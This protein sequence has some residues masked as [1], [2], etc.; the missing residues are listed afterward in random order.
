MNITNYNQLIW[1]LLLVP[2]LFFIRKSLVNRRVTFRNLAAVLRI[3]ALICLILALT[4]PFYTSSTTDI[5]AIFLID[6]SSSVD[7]NALTDSVTKITTAINSLNNNDSYGIYLFANGVKPVTLENLPTTI[8]KLGT[9]I[10]SSHFRSKSA[11]AEAVNDIK[12]L[13]PANKSKLLCLFSDGIETEGGLASAL[14]DLREN[15]IKLTLKKLSSFEKPEVS[16]VELKANTKRAYK[17]EVIRVTAKLLSNYTTKAKLRFLVRGVVVHEVP[18]NL[19]KNKETSLTYEFDLQAENSGIWTAEVVPVKDYFPANNYASCSVDMLGKVK[20]LVL[21][22][23]PTKLRAFKKAI[24]KQEVSV[25]IRTKVGVPSSFSELCEYDAVMLADIE[26]DSFTTRQ[27]EFM[28]KY[29][30]DFGG[31]LIMTGSENS[32]GLGG[33]Y[34]TPIEKVLPLNSRYEKEKEHPSLALVLIIDKSGSMSGAP[35]VLAREAAR[36]VLEVL[37]IRDQIGIIAFDGSAKVVA[38]LTSAVNKSS[39][40]NAIETIGAGGGTN[41]YPAME[42]GRDLLASASAKIKHM[43][44]LSDGQSSGGDF[45]GIASDLASMNVT[46]STVSLGQGAAVNLM[47]AIA[48]IGNGRAYVTTNAEDMPRIFTKE[49]IEA[50][51]SAIKEEPFI[52]IKISSNNSI[53]GIDIENA[54]FLLGYIMTKAKPSVDVLLLTEAGDPLLASGQFGLGKSVGFTSDITNQWAG[55]WLDWRNFGKFWA[56]IIRS[57]TRNDNNSNL[58]L[59]LSQQASDVSLTINCRDNNDNPENHISWDTRLIDHSGNSQKVVTKQTGFGRYTAQFTPPKD[60]NYALRIN[61]LTNNRVKT[62]FKVAKYAKEYQLSSNPEVC[63][64][65]SK[66]F[67]ADFSE[68]RTKKMIQNSAFNSFSIIAIILLLISTFFRRV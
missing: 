59:K 55:E 33:Y 12:M 38:E 45:E 60:G 13:Y 15:K 19:I 54:P 4:R 40:F 22:N 34:K 1:L 23:K 18:A 21:H 42:R 61:D 48:K 30:T 47:E 16:V 41:M 52:P 37:S 56:Q 28:R 17:G 27:M 6:A 66:K 44:V 14:Q 5:H 11:I 20:L 49:T 3:S 25:E 51:R 9:D 29:V 8:K 10:S 58:S 24:E 57:V 68:L 2:V 62:I 63:L 65:N 7:L 26:A 36:S 46:I 53:A 35:I 39:V 50:S 32:F 43:I 64:L 31:G 67:T